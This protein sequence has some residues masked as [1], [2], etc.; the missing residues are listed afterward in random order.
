MLLTLYLVSWAVSLP[1]NLNCN[2]YASLKWFAGICNY[3]ILE[4]DWLYFIRSKLW[5]S[6]Q[7]IYRK[8]KIAKSRGQL[9]QH[10]LRKVE[11]WWA[12]RFTIG[13]YKE[14]RQNRY[15]HHNSKGRF[16]VYKEVYRKAVYRAFWVDAERKTFLILN[17]WLWAYIYVCLHI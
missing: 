16:G 3:E 5:N 8:Q 4:N 14:Q 9:L 11:K 2:L 15:S 13:S 7:D 1:A 17:M 10:D 12:P 6:P